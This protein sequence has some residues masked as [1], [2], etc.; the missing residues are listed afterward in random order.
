MSRTANVNQK[1]WSPSRTDI[2]SLIEEATVDA[3]G[4]AEQRTGFYTMLEEHLD[5][6]FDVAILGD[7]TTVA[8]IDMAA[9]EQI[10][11]ICKR[12]R[13]KHAIRVLDLP[14]PSPPPACAEWIEAYRRWARGG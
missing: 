13:F 4:D 1:R 12:G 7:R 8:R 11:A 6:P 5:M 10:V 2:K 3:Y 14:L 9:D